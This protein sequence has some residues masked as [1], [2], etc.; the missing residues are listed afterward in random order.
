MRNGTCHTANAE[1]YFAL[2]LRLLD[3]INSSAVRTL[4]ADQ[5]GKELDEKQIKQAFDQSFGAGAGERVRMRCQSV[6]GRSVITGLTI[7]LSGE[8]SGKAELAELIQAAA[9]TEFKCGKGI[10]AAAGRG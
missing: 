5:I 8:L 7:G 4:F 2:Q 9:P 1:D 3:E 6:N 10:A